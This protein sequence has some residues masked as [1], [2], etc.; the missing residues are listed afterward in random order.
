MVTK[1]K[2]MK[3]KTK[4][5]S[6]FPSQESLGNN[7][8]RGLQEALN[9]YFNTSNDLRSMEL[10]YHTAG[11][12]GNVEDIIHVIDNQFEVKELYAKV[13]VELAKVNGLLNPHLSEDGYAGNAKRDAEWIYEEALKECK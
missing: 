5:Q 7:A 4:Y 8:L 1:P 6:M 2:T 9:Q 13:A 12:N 11:I 10:Q 3:P